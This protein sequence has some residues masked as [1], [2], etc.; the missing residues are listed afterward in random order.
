MSLDEWRARI[1][2]IDRQ[3]LDLLN[4]RA[5]AAIQVGRIK[6]DTGAERYVPEREQELLERLLRLNPGPLPAGA[7][8]AIWREIF[9]ASLT[10][11]RPLQIAYLGPEATFTHQAALQ[12]FGDSA[13]Y[14]AAR[15]IP[16]IFAEVERGRA[17]FGVVP[18]EN[19][20]EGS[21]NHTLDR[22]IDSPL[23]I[24]GEILLEIHHALLGRA[25]DL[26]GVKVVYSHPQALAQCRQW[27]AAELPDVPPVEVAS[28]AAAVERAR[29]E[30]TAAAIA[31]ELA[32][33][34]YDL[35]VLRSRIEDAAHNV[36]RFLIIGLRAM[37]PSG[38]DKTSILFS[39]KDEVGALY[40]MLEPFAA[41]AL[42][43]TR[44][45]SRP[46]K[47]RPWEYVFF[48]DFEGHRDDPAVH[49]ALAEL[50]TR[51][52]FLKVLGSYPSAA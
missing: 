15:G 36:T 33:R 11:Q 21:V 34:L 27:L 41:N 47:R 17:D 42:N 7:I 10:L 38:R 50:R 23:L 4:Q 43:L 12:G 9:S 48:V 29:E 52:L 25:P 35:P 31:S 13:E 18:V 49:A 26:G 2:A 32:G 20:T 30:P 44:I 46:T 19:S 1:D 24:S 51:C 5:E 37:G 16:E 6:Q 40:R 14:L 39:I 22:L 45:E 3:I 8:R 28:T